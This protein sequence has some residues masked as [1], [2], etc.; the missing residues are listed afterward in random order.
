MITLNNWSHG[1]Y[2]Y[3]AASCHVERYRELLESD[4]E[5]AVRPSIV[6]RVRL[7]K[8]LG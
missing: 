2:Y 7:L 3:I 5:K 6:N 1:L 8:P 4:P